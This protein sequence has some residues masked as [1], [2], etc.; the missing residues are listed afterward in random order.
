MLQHIKTWVRTLKIKYLRFKAIRGLKK[1][2]LYAIEVERVMEQFATQQILLGSSPES[3]N[4]SRGVL[5][6]HQQVIRL[7]EDFQDF[8]DS[9]K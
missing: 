7:K 6:K 3:V 8:L 2:N 5:I 4:Q 9:I 1:S